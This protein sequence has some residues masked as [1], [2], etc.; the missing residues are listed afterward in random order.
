LQADLDLGNY[1]RF[2]D[3]TLTRDHNITT[4]KV[5]ESHPTAHCLAQFP[6]KLLPGADFLQVYSQV[7]QCERRGDYL[8]KTVQ[9]IPH[10]TDAIQEWIERVAHISVD[11]A[12]GP[13]DICLIEVGGT[14]GDIESLVFLE[15]LRQFRSRVGADNIFFFHVSLVPV[16]GAVGEQKTKPTQ[17]SVKELRSVGISPDAIICRSSLPLESSTR[18]KLG[19]FC[20]VPV[21]NVLAVHDVSNIYHV[22]LLLHE[23][24]ADGIIMKH[25]RLTPKVLQPALEDW[26]QLAATVDSLAS[27]PAVRIALVGKYTGLSDSYLS[28]IKSL[29][30]AAIAAKQRL[31]IEWIDAAALEREVPPAAAPIPGSADAAAAPL[32]GGVSSDAAAP[33]LVAKS[34]YQECWDTLR[35]AHGILVPGGFGD[36]GVEGKMLAIQHARENKVPFLGIC[37]G[38]QCAVL[39]FARNVCGYTGA[40]STE[41]DADAAHPVVVFMPEINQAQMGGTMRLGGR[42][43]VL[44]ARQDGKGSLA[45]ALY[46]KVPAISERHRHRYEVNPEYVPSI[47]AKGLH[48]TGTD[49]RKQR[50]EIIE[51]DRAQHPFFFAVQYHPEFNSHPYRPSPPFLGLMFA[52][53]GAL[54]EN[55][56]LPHAKDS[57]A[58]YAHG[59]ASAAAAGGA[60]STIMQA[61]LAATPPPHSPVAATPTSGV[62]ASPSVS[63][64]LGPVVGV[65][66][67]IAVVEEVGVSGSVGQGTPAS[68]PR[69]GRATPIHAV[70]AAAS[71][72]ASAVPGGMPAVQRSYQR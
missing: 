14:V 35:A 56:P 70:P 51:L 44:Q 12:A 26:R 28:V 60:R 17:H 33:P 47:A 71:A 39:E 23:Q 48:F 2:L 21:A 29:K 16:L 32:T 54:E 58:N 59:A 43:T 1:E 66:Q 22:P 64:G 7:I 37:L 62:I 18:R 49:E 24:Q 31:V 34:A 65:E 67:S 10:V 19:L 72:P 55:L 4:G 27:A 13:P 41:F 36:R 61:A 45:E 46:G 69:M 25:L 9:V 15:A 5:R 50:M 8:G 38:M 11:G 6:H 68:P 53:V 3:I 63:M 57:L 30:H 52:A 42:S 20:Q 40:T